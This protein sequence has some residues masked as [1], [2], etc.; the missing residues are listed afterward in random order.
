MKTIRIN[1]K[2]SLLFASLALAISPA[3]WAYDSAVNVGLGQYSLDY[4]DQA[5]SANG[6]TT[7]WRLGYVG[8][9]N[10]Y[11]GFEIRLG[12]TGETSAAG[13]KLNPALFLSPLFRPSFPVGEKVKLY[14]LIGFTSLAVGRTTATATE[15][16]IARVGGSL[17]VGAD[18]YFNEHMAAGIELISY[19]RN[20]DY[21]PNSDTSNWTGVTQAKVSLS[22]ITASFKYQF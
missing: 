9:F 15:E 4:Q 16:I 13:L 17:G 3:A 14:G 1:R 12:G 7:G 2:F 11:L 10:E 19:Q 21:G 5:R 20:V 6:K 22:S 18:F 8:R